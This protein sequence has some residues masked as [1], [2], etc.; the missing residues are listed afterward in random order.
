MAQVPFTY[1]LVYMYSHNTDN[2]KEE[3]LNHLRLII[4][5]GKLKLENKQ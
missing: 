5:G 1:M 3:E 2:F 4:F